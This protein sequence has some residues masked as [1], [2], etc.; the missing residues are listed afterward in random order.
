MAKGIDQWLLA[1]FV[2]LADMVV[3]IYCIPIIC[4]AWRGN[5]PLM[6]L[7]FVGIFA[8]ANSLANLWRAAFS[9]SRRHAFAPPL[10]FQ[11]REI[12]PVEKGGEEHV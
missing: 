12:P 10:A 2:S 3:F 7:L 9:S 4:L 6:A 11:P 8:W 1:G 5:R